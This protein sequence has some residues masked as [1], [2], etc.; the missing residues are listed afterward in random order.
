MT[1][2]ELEALVTQQ[3]D[4]IRRLTDMIAELQAMQRQQATMPHYT[5]PVVPDTI[6]IMPVTPSPWWSQTMC[7]YP[8][9]LSI[10]ENEPNF[11]GFNDI[12]R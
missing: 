11:T 3:A 12:Q 4:T 5:P 10:I 8:Q 9:K 1:K 7:G 6:K 2:K